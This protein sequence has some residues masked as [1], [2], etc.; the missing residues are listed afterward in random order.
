[1]HVSRDSR[2]EREEGVAYLFSILVDESD[3]T[4]GQDIVELT[5][6]SCFENRQF[7][8]SRIPHRKE[9]YHLP[10]E[11]V[12]HLEGICNLPS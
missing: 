2:A 7:R 6:E 4:S 8:L 11:V 10:K 3:R 12:I 1:M 9:A 5:E